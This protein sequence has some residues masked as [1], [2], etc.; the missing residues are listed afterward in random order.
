[1]RNPTPLALWGLLILF[2]Y[3]SPAQS[4]V[5]SAFS[6][7]KKLQSDNAARYLNGVFV[8]GN[9]LADQIINELPERKLDL[10]ESTVSILC[11]YIG[12]YIVI[13]KKN[14]KEG[15]TYLKEAQ[16][17]AVKNSGF[18][19]LIYYQK[20]SELFKSL[21]RLDS[22]IFYGRK[23]LDLARELKHD[24]LETVALNYTG[25]LYYDA[26]Q[27][28]TCAQYFKTVLSKPSVTMV[29]KRNSYNTIGLC[30]R[31]QKIY[32][33]ALVY[34]QRSLANIK[35]DDTFYYGLVVGNM[36][37]TYYLQE[38]YR[39][40]LPY[41]LTELK[42]A[43]HPRLS[44][45]ALDCLNTIA[46]LY[47]NLDDLSHAKIYYDSLTHLMQSPHAGSTVRLNYLKLS[48]NY[49]Q[50]KGDYKKAYQF[51]NN[52]YSLK[53]S[54]EAIKNLKLAEEVNA[55]YDF[56]SQRKEI[57]LLHQ[58]NLVH[59]ANEKQQTVL[60]YGSLII[61]VLITGLLFVLYR[62]QRHRK[63]SFELMKQH[64]D[65]VEQVNE[66]LKVNLEQIEKKN[67]EIIELAGHLQEVNATKDKLFSIIGH[68]LRNPIQA[69]KGLLSLLSMEGITKE[70]FF[71]FSGKLK[72]GVEHIEFTMNN[73]LQW[74]RNQMQGL[75]T[76][77][78]KINL[79]RLVAENINFITAG[80]AIKNI[81][82]LNVIAENIDVV[83]DKDQLNLVIRNLISNALKF[84]PDQGKIILDCQLEGKRAV[85]TITDT[86]IGMDDETLNKLFKKNIHYTTSGTRG[87]KGSGLGLLLC[88]EMIQKNDG[89][90][91]VESKPGK[92][93]IFY[94][95]LPLS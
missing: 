93:T 16:S 57:E 85:I 3:N 40:A 83:A 95:A 70:E 15:F 24:S 29:L 17:L 54:L 14:I 68:D 12:E 38:K 22:A 8:P 43:T 81:Q 61:L 35:K 73:I 63:K 66:E 20:H 62:N 6:K 10:S 77:R 91:W 34:F 87:E 46:N 7:L 23:M 27:Y 56:D 5:D 89:K 52:F 2:Y 53:D 82:L 75:Q 25:Y 39:E 76:S 45:T 26:Q 21:P 49:Y 28:Q 11:S 92:G 44:K 64:S 42:Y 74:A 18:P 30:F 37:D 19:L 41:L 60:L 48:S 88:Y 78:L 50:K 13:H 32:D 36:G 55:Q 33:S 65:Y 94:I 31:N 51:N 84:T 59:Q 67:K 9:S 69:L 79:K 47:I 80:S 90:L 86:G 72:E 1:M 71:G 58:Q 4:R